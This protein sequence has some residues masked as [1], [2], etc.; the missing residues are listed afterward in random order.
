MDGPRRQPA[1]RC[2][3]TRSP[4][5]RFLEGLDGT[6]RSVARCS[7]TPLDTPFVVPS[8]YLAPESALSEGRDDET[9]LPEGGVGPSVAVAAQGDQPVAIE[10]RAPLGALYH[11]MDLE[12]GRGEATGLA[13]PAGAGQN[14]GPD[15]APRLETRRRA[16]ERQR[17]SRPD[18]VARSLSDPRAGGEPARALHEGPSEFYPRGQTRNSDSGVTGRHLLDFAHVGKIPIFPLW[19]R[20]AFAGPPGAPTPASTRGSRPGRSQSDWAS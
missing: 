19:R 20:S 12:A 9:T 1:A 15:L 16:A 7:I 11:V 10:V 18:A 17:T 5:H 2:C 14:V 4:R 13:A 6:K 8:P 3:L